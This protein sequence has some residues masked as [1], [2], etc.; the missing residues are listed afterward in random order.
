MIGSRV[1]VLKFWCG[2]EQGVWKG[3]R[4]K[5]EGRRGET[6][7]GGDRGLKQNLGLV[8]GWEGEALRWPAD[9]SLYSRDVRDIVIMR[10]GQMHKLRITISLINRDL[11]RPCAQNDDR[12]LGREFKK[13]S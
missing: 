11:R 13:Y 2:M 8:K 9:Y 4:D 10:D 12:G 1:C 5:E 6:G 7:G 3:V